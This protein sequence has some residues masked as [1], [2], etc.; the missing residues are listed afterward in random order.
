M[1]AAAGG[2]TISPE[3]AQIKLIRGNKKGKVWLQD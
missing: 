3:I 2:V 1:I